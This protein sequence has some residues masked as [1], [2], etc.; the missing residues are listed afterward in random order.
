MK[1]DLRNN[2]V[3]TEKKLD[4]ILEQLTEIKVVQAT[5][6]VLHKQNSKDLE[7][8]IHRTD[9]NEQRIAELEDAKIAQALQIEKAKAMIKTVGWVLGTIGTLILGLISVLEGLK[10]LL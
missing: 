7:D 10:N 1:K 2:A 9:L 8:H 4:Q 5:H 6:T 3:S